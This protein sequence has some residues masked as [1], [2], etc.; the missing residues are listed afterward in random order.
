VI[1]VVQIPAPSVESVEIN[2]GEGQRSSITSVTVTFDRL[3]NVPASAFS[4]TNVGSPAAPQTIP[5]TSIVVDAA[6]IDGKTVASLTFSSGASVSDRATGNTL[7]DGRYELVVDASQVISMDDLSMAGDYSFGAGAADSFFR[8]YGDANGS[9]VV[10]LFDFAA[11]RSAFGTSVGDAGYIDGLDANGDQTINL[12]DF[13]EF[14]SR[15][16]G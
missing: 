3:V 14:R 4:L 13:A 11:F 5:V 6:E 2:D 1:G 9:G 8:K 16:G 7:A 15:F 12:F 10:D